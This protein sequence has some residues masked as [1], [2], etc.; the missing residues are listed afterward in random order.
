VLEWPP[1]RAV[2]YPHLYAT[3]AEYEARRGPF[4]AWY[5]KELIPSLD[6][7]AVLE[8]IRDV[9]LKMADEA[10]Q[11]MLVNPE[12]PHHITQ[13]I[14]PV[15]NLADLVL[16]TG[17]LTSEQEASLRARMAFMAY[18]LNWRGYW[19]PEKGYAANPNMSSFTYDGVGLLGLLLLDHPESQTWINACTTQLDRELENWVSADGAWIE[20]IHYTLAASPESGVA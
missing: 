13:A 9:V 6:D 17:V 4:N 11:R 18:V 5:G 16:G 15:A 12:P 20:S 8:K 10:V 7:K 19:A 14:Y 1:D 2:V 3:K